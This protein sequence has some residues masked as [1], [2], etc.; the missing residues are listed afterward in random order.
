MLAVRGAATGLLAVCLLAIGTSAASAV[1][2]PLPDGSA[3]SYL[4]I[5][6]SKP[7]GASPR[8]FDALFDNLDYNG[9]P[10]MTSNTNYTFY[11][12]PSGTSGYPAGFT[13][14]VNKYFEDLAHDSG[15][16]QN[17]DSVANQYN[18]AAGGFSEYNSKFAGQL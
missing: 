7:A 15:G 13:T 9:G 3:V 17:V 4:P 16:H 11:W 2:A 14:G 18:S 8:G 12:S 6:V 1:I 10:V 5:P